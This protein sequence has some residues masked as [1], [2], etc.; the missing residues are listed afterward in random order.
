MAIIDPKK[1]DLRNLSKLVVH[2]TSSR[3]DKSSK[4]LGAVEI[5]DAEPALTLGQW[6]ALNERAPRD[7]E[8]IP[9][10]GWEE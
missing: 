10:E 2:T 3:S 5:A 1:I 6:Q 8:I 7:L 9:R 4:N